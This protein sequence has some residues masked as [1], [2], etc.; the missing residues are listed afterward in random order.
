MKKNELVVITIPIPVHFS[1]EEC[2]W[3]LNRNYDDC[4]H[5]VLDNEIRKAIVIEGAPLLI[6]VVGK[7]DHLRITVLQGSVT[8]KGRLLLTTYIREWFDM[9]R[10]MTPFYALLQKDKKVAYMAN[11]FKGLRL[12]GIDDLFEVLCWAIIG[13]Q[14]NLTFAY[15]LKRRLVE[16]Y[17]TSLSF[18][19]RDYHLFP[20]SNILAEAAVDDLRAMQF[21]QRKA[22]YLIG[23]AK[24]F[25]SGALSKAQLQAL[26][27]LEERRKALTDLKGIGVWTA[28]YAL[29]KSL[30]EHS[31]IPHG[32]IGLLNALVSHQI[33]KERGELEKIDRFFKKYQGWE[34]YLV[35]Y[36][37][38]SLAAPM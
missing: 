22:E 17:G 10:D 19:E 7:T 33:I 8:D 2:A 20:A 4:L 5:A 14:I 12:I 30:R 13:Q 29:M 25:D 16:K 36:L 6:S 28:N 15:K 23:V 26:P 24:A 31:C 35:F 9:D 27:D 34:S 38:R 32:D 11:D 18:E 37:W 3:F 21:S 1:L